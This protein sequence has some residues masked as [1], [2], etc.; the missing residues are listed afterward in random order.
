MR[1]SAPIRDMNGVPPLSW[2]PLALPF[3]R[4]GS[5]PPDSMRTGRQGMFLPCRPYL[6]P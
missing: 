3:I 6:I 1:R 2:S 5:T 4:M